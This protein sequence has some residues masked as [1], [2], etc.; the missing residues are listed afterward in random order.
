MSA[1]DTVN[2]KKAKFFSCFFIFFSKAI[3]ISENI[4]YNIVK[5]VPSGVK[6]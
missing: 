1:S 5:V 6:W 2:R 4:S 3:V